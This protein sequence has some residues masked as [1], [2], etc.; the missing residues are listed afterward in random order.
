MVIKMDNDLIQTINCANCNANVP[1]D[2]K[3]CTECGK[4]MEQV[5]TVETTKNNTSCPQ[6][7]SEVED[8]LK[9]CTECGTKIEKV[10][11]FIETK[12]P[13]CFAEL[14]PGTQFCTECGKKL[15]LRSAY[16][17]ACP[18]CNVDN[19]PGLKF[20]TECGTSLEA[21]KSYENVNISEELKKRREREGKSIPPQDE[22]LD[23]L[24][25]SGKGLM[26][27]LGGF[28]DKTAAELDKN[29]NQAT[30]SGSKS[31]IHDIS[32]KFKI[33][34]EKSK[35][36]YLVCDSCGGYYELQL[37]ESPDDYSDECDCGGRLKHQLKI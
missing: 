31:P 19:E 26:K 33:Q 25:T 15:G 6:C 8:G 35:P 12:C 28:L 32:Q 24:V 21:K 2:T 23:T 30:K 37:D 14:T 9:F 36:G 34:R 4:P 11:T 22:T 29:I 16:L 3:F 5:R 17:T 7:N 10:S 20:C 27:G 1:E 13:K 18:K